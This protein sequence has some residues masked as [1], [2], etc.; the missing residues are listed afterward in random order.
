MDDKY[1]S[2]IAKY[3]A[4]EIAEQEREA[5]FSLVNSS[6][7]HKAYF[8]EMQELWGLSVFEEKDPEIDVDKA[9][10]KIDQRINIPIEEKKP[11]TKVFRIGQL[12]KIAALFIGVFAAFWLFKML[13]NDPG[14]MILVQTL[15]QQKQQITLPD[16]S[17]VWL[18]ANSKLTYNDH[19]SPRVVH[20]EGEAFFEVTH[21]E[22]HSR[23]EIISGDTKTTVLGTSFNVRAYPEEEK[24]EVTVATG[25]V[26][27]EEQQPTK[28]KV[29]KKEVFLVA[30]Q[31]G[32][33]EK[34]QAKVTKVQKTIVNADAWQKEELDF[35]DVKFSEVIKSMQR[36]YNIE[37]KTENPKLLNCPVY[38]VYT[39]PD[40]KTLIQTIEVMIEAES[41]YEGNTLVFSGR[42][43]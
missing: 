6:E 38:G 31:S 8:E 41:R 16:S 21:Q 10:N 32:V 17:K 35:Q 28:N 11:E 14:Q 36:Y 2:L 12:L 13:N 42:G 33:Y 15:D 25:K 24:V 37:I 18:N 20:L 40:L 39:K 19:F 29:A 7:E 22:D 23:F 5:L 34:Q 9:W 3:L 4:G 30:G 27:L 26:K 43:C 1:I